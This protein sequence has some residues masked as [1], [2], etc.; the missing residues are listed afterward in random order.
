MKILVTN[1]DG[2]SAEGIAALVKALSKQHEV[3]LVAPKFNQSAV[4]H[5]LTL[6][7]PMRIERVEAEGAKEAYCINGTPADCARMALCVLGIHPDAVVSGINRAGNIGTDVLYS[8]TVSAA[9][10]AAMLGCRALAVSKDTLSLDY[11]DD[12]AAHF[13]ENFELFFGCTTAEKRLININYPNI[14]RSEY[15]GIRAAYLAEQVYANDYER[16]ELEDGGVGYITPSNK[17]TECAEND[18]SDEKYIRDGF[19][20]VTPLKYDVTDYERLA[21]ISAYIE[22]NY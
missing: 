22:K 3:I 4:G 7:V 15:R 12:A 5:G 13:A 20:T 21:K 18:T 16:V 14:P 2:Y 10:E 11:F 1:D 6:R 19:V 9:E 17:I 8:G